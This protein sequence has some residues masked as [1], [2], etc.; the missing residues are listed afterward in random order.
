MKKDLMDCKNI[1]KPA[2]A[3]EKDK[4]EMNRMFNSKRDKRHKKDCR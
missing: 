3:K 2:K 1:V 4:K